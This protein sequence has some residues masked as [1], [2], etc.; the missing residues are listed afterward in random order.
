MVQ[1]EAT[2]IMEEVQ[3]TRVTRAQFE[4]S[5]PRK[6]TDSLF[7]RLT[8]SIDQAGQQDEGTWVCH[9]DRKHESR[10]IPEA[11]Q[12]AQIRCQLLS[13]SVSITNH[14]RAGVSQTRQEV[15]SF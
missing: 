1:D 2:L 7:D 6:Y 12:L 8:Q 14:C 13:A 5:L 15:H 10:L 3:W 4:L 11:G 9:E